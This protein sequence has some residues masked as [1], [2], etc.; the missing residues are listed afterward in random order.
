MTPT[1]A[2]SLPFHIYGCVD[3]TFLSAGQRDGWEPAVLFGLT[4]PLNRTLGLTVLLECGAVYRDLPPHAWAFHPTPEPDW[5]LTSAQAWDCFGGSAHVLEYRYL[6][7]F[8]VQIIRSGLHASY[9]FTVEFGEDGFSRN[10]EQSKCLHALE[11]DNG[12]LT[13]QPNDRLLF[14]DASFT[15]PHTPDWLRRPSTVYG[16][17]TWPSDITPL[18]PRA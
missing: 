2:V 7:E 12:R 10:P 14:H 8:P 13:L 1:L 6:R 17:E 18:A 16:V 3:R 15:T 4:C 9:L 5:P 11:L